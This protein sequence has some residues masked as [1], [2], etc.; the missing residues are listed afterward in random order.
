MTN[1]EMEKKI[2]WLRD[3]V[4]GLDE[5]VLTIE[6][7]KYGIYDDC[8]PFD[9]DEVDETDRRYL[10]D[11]DEY[12]DRLRAMYIDQGKYDD[13]FDNRDVARTALLKKVCK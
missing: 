9:P 11:D 3:F 5:R 12:Y 13:M 1:R 2:K 10:E 7:E 8:E 4:I 6:A